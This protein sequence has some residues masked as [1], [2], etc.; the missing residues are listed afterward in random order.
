M[1]K[2]IQNSSAYSEK[3]S[4]AQHL[5]NN[6]SFKN[7]SA[8][9]YKEKYPV[10]QNLMN[11]THPA[12]HGSKSFLQNKHNNLRKSQYNNEKELLVQLE[13]RNFELSD[14][15][16]PTEQKRVLVKET[17]PQAHQIFK[18]TFQVPLKA[19]ERVLPA[20]RSSGGRSEQG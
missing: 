20:R 9:G 1:A 7:V 2:E 5:T 8:S 19:R 15:L 12:P 4:S 6:P 13:N 11:E 3:R 17:Q 18:F 10:N 14:V 16:E